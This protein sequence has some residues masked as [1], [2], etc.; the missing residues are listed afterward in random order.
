MMSMGRRRLTTGACP[1]GA[2]STTSW[3]ASRSIWQGKRE[4]RVDWH[5]GEISTITPSDGAGL[6]IGYHFDTLGGLEAVT[7]GR[8]DGARFAEG[9]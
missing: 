3:A 6:P 8:A 2:P 1:A 5:G 7:V 4:L 9:Q